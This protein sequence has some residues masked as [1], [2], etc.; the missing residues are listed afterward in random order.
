MLSAF[1]SL[2][3]VFILHLVIFVF[4]LILIFFFLVSL[5]VFFFF[6]FFQ[7]EDGIRDYKVTGVQTCALPISLDPCSAIATLVLSGCSPIV[8]VTSISLPLRATL[9]AALVPIGVLVTL[10][11]K[12]TGSCTDEPWYPMM[13]SPCLIPACS[14]GLSSLTSLTSAPCVCVNPNDLARSWVTSWIPTPRY[15]RTTLPVFTR[16][17]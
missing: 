8:T 5:H 6:F 16:L 4:M 3:L 14:A 9:T 15:P 12:A 1:T 10:R 7:A 11:C 13:T 17:S 2:C